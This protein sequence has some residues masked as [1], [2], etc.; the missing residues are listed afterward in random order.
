MILLY[1]LAYM[2]MGMLMLP[3]VPLALVAQ[4]MQPPAADE[5]R[6]GERA[7]RIYPEAKAS[8][9]SKARGPFF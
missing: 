3:W 5:R 2:T 1:P 7:P 6:G 8:G 9:I 4:A